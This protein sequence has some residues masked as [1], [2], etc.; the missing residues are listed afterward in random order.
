MAEQES[1][2][3]EKT[4]QKVADQIQVSNELIT[5]H[6]VETKRIFGEVKKQRKDF[7]KTHK[8]REK[9]EKEADKD[10]SETHKKLGWSV[11]KKPSYEII[12]NL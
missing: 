10:R 6:S 9:A 4:L 8:K 5:G 3:Q 11:D 2:T 7:G 12:K 1:T